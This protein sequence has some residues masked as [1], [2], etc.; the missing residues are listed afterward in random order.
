MSKTEKELA[1]L[2]DLVIDEG[3]TQRF[4]DILD[5]DFKVAGKKDILYVNAGTGSHA[6]VLKNKMRKKVPLHGVVESAELLTIAEAKAAV[7][8]TDVVFSTEFPDDTFDVVLADASF[9][10]PDDLKPLIEKVVEHAENQVFFFLP[11]AGS[12]GEIY[13]LLWESFFNADLLAHSV[14][15]E[16]LIIELPTVSEAEDIAT[17]AGLHDVKAVTKIE[18]FDFKDSKEFMEAPLLADFLLPAWLGFL[19][20]KE[21]KKV[22]KELAKLIDR[23][24]TD[25][26]FRFSVKATLITGGKTSKETASE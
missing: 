6:L 25:L 15:V 3:W 9:T 4:T 10:A 22:C 19:N 23:E 20:D 13:S 2:R 5:N 16:R 11:T 26:T 8:D 1:F 12:F 21:Q 7:S 17:G 24:S 18:H 14:A